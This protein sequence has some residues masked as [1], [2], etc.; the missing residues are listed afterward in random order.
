MKFNKYRIFNLT[1]LINLI[2]M[3]HRLYYTIL[4]DYKSTTKIFAFWVLIIQYRFY[5]ISGSENNDFHF[6]ELLL[7]L[8]LWIGQK[9]QNICQTL[10]LVLY[11]SYVIIHGY[12]CIYTY[13][14]SDSTL[15]MK[16]KLKMK[17]MYLGSSVNTMRSSL[18]AAC[19]LLNIYYLEKRGMNCSTKLWR[20][21]SSASSSRTT[22]IYKSWSCSKLKW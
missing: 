1:I 9:S 3:I 6:P 14:N 10:I 8:D 22:C 15:E 7:A 21:S 17:P 4:L 12:I 11:Y 13:S 16:T 2:E 20:W 18:R 19:N 5:Y